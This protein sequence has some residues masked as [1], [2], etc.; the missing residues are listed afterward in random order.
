MMIYLFIAANLLIERS[1]SVL[2]FVSSSDVLFR[3][4]FVLVLSLA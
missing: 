3:F 1:Y 4:T 2:F